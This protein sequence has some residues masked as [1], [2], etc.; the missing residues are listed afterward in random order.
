MLCTYT[1]FCNFNRINLF[2]VDSTSLAKYHMRVEKQ[3]CKNIRALKPRRLSRS[4][5]NARP[6]G[7]QGSVNKFTIAEDR[8]FCTITAGRSAASELCWSVGNTSWK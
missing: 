4:V 2:A 7:P 3:Q 1:H 5:A 6:P 8:N